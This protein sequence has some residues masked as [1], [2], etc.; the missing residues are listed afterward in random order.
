MIVQPVNKILNG[1]QV[2]KIPVKI[3]REMNVLAGDGNILIY[4]YLIIYYTQS[5]KGMNFCFNRTKI[6]MN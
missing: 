6:V 2:L 1:T 3:L 4:F 5:D